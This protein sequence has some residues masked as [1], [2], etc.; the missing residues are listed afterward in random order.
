VNEPG[1]AGA[2]GALGRVLRDQ[3]RLEDAA[4]SYRKAAALE[5]Q[6]A[7]FH[8][9]LGNVL[10][11][12]GMLAE[13]IA[14]YQQA[15]ETCP[16]YAEAYNNLANLNQMT[17]RLEEAAA[18]YQKAISL[19]AD[20][21]EAYRNLGSLLCRQGKLSEAISALRSALSLDPGY[22]EATAL[23]EHQMRHACEWKG[24]D[25]L[26]RSL[27]YMV[28]QG[29]GSVNPFGF[30][31]LESTPAQQLLC[32]RQWA[33]QNVH[34]TSGETPFPFGDQDNDDGQITVGYLSADF[35]EHATAHLISELFSR[36]D[37][38]RFRIVGYSYGPDDG[39]PARERL[40]TSF[41]RFV[42]IQNESFVESARR[43][44]ADG[45]QILVDLKGY[46]AD[47]RPK[48]MALRPA[49]IQ[50]NYL[51]YP[52]TMGSEAI[53]YVIV[54]RIVVP[55]QEQAFFTERLVHLPNCYQANDSTRM[56]SERIPSR[57]QC[58]LPERGFVFCC[59]NASYK[60][61]PKVFNVWIRLL[62]TV[63]KGV[64][65]LLDSNPYATANLKREAEARGVGAERLVFAGHLP[66]PDHLARFAVADLFLDTFPY[67]AHTLTSDALWGGCPV[68]TY[69][70][71]T[72]PS[73]V[74]GS[75]LRSVGLPELVCGSLT[76]YEKLASALA[77]DPER[78]LGVRQK[79]R[80][81]RSAAP[82]FDTRRFA[83][84]LEA[85][86]ETM[87]ELHRRGETSRPF[88]VSDAM[89]SGGKGVPVREH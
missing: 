3:G 88:A 80:T 84:H 69:S 4:A 12:Q 52:G 76:E 2:H 41:D 40:I 68:V 38:N 89:D 32:A 6:N 87:W 46:T 14:C 13:A 11:E 82:V 83:R 85:A 25:A 39:S 49:P 71:R 74:A 8:N 53:D 22:G 5:P 54:D 15:L 45:V 21:A 27:I 31:C 37:R 1:T 35:H 59:F 51:G 72:F 20:Y 36:H 66:Y 78:L 10:A 86:F 57:Q 33:A 63:P 50:V 30:L 77:R 64:L 26:S 34:C 18:G 73:R 47:A 19:R 62:K 61:T 56:I 42:D 70:G 48:I 24:L 75:L 81:A 79:L 29:S 17:G 67:N 7:T 16:D 55:P 43:I 44:R 28:E 65:W 58:G 60:I 9:D 23:L